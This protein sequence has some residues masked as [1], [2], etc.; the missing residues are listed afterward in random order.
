MPIL[1]RLIF[2]IWPARAKILADAIVERFVKPGGLI[3]IRVAD[4]MSIV[5]AVDLQESDTPSGTSAAYD[6]FA[7]LGQDEKIYRDIAARLLVRASP[8]LKATPDAWVSFIAFAATHRGDKGGKAAIKQA[9]QAAATLSTIGSA[10]HVKASA[11]GSRSSEFDEVVVRLAIEPGYHIN[12]NPASLD[13]LVPTTVQIPGVKDA[14]VSYPPGQVFKPK[15]SDEAILVYEGTAL[16]K[17]RLAKGSIDKSKPA[18][19]AVEVQACTVKLCLEPGQISVP[20]V[21]R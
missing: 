21:L 6:L 4:N 9:S 2:S 16:I 10:K 7:K 3:L 8:K 5:P 13:F 12:A 14:R 18:S 11:S 17:M 19:V 20:I 1:L 15:F